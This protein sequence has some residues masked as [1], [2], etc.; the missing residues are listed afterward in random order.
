VLKNFKLKEN[1]AQQKKEFQELKEQITQQRGQLNKEKAE[2]ETAKTEYTNSLKKI[3][4]QLK[5]ASIEIETHMSNVK[6]L[7]ES[8][9]RLE[10][11]LSDAKI[12]TGKK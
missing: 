9:R 8:N 7:T 10:Q 12:L 3:E 11:E 4:Y 2:Q 6:D 1:E 5:I